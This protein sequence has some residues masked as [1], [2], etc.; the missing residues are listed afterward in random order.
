MFA[1]SKI[2]T[3]W[4]EIQDSFLSSLSNTLQRGNNMKKFLLGVLIILLFLGSISHVQAFTNE[5]FGFSFEPPSGWTTEE[6]TN[7]VVFSEPNEEAFIM[8]AAEP[9]DLTLQEVVSEISEIPNTENY[10]LVSERYMIV[11]GVDAYEQVFSAKI[12]DSEIKEKAI[13]FIKYDHIYFVLY[14]TPIAMYDEHMSTFDAS[15]ATLEIMEPKGLPWYVEYQ[16][17]FLI[18][19]IAAA[20]T[21]MFYR[22]RSRRKNKPSDKNV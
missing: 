18:V 20:G 2:F 5:A 1:R 17:V 14:Q 8:V 9:T 19:A 13:V 3:L 12:E 6:Q 11:N 21:F 4:P 10:T 22:M 7:I 16:N 15:F